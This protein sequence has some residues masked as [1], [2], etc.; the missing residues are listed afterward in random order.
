MPQNNDEVQLNQG[1]KILFMFTCP[2]GLVHEKMLL[3]LIH[4]QLAHKHKYDCVYLTKLLALNVHYVFCCHFLVSNFSFFS[5]TVTSTLLENHSTTSW[6]FWHT[7]ISDN[8]KNYFKTVYWYLHSLLI[9][10]VMCTW[11]CWHLPISTCKKQ[12]PA[13]YFQCVFHVLDYCR[14]MEDL[15]LP[16]Q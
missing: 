13:L 1:V 12:Q 5:F 6:Y 11:Y 14:S 4:C 7:S 2:V 16:C 10:L 8:V 9:H 15:L 3:A